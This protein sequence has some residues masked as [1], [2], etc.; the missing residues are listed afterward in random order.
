M[1][2]IGKNV[3][4]GRISEILGLDPAGP[5]FS[6]NNPANRL[7]ADDANYVEALHTNGPTFLLI[8]AGIGAPIAHAD[9]F[10][11]GGTSQPGC[12]LNSCSHSRA[13]DFYRKT[14]TIC[15]EFLVK[16]FF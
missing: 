3:R 14:C 15:F 1:G 9:F 4:N 8:G 16:F 10:A 6:V 12:T 11:N 13:V 5:L 7:D 2:H